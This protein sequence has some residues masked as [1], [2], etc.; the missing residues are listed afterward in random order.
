M[1]KITTLCLILLMGFVAYAQAPAN[2]VCAGAIP[3]TPSPE[4]GACTTVTLPFSTDGTTDSGVQNASCSASGLD[5]FFTWT[6]TTDGLFFQSLSPG[7]PGIAIYESCADAIAG[8][9]LDC[10]QT[11]AAGEL[12]GWDIGDDL[13]I[14]IYDF[15]GSTSDVAFCLQEFTFPLP[16]ANDD[17]VNAIAMTDGFTFSLDSGGATYDPA[18]DTCFRNN[19]DI[20]Y[21]FNDGGTPVEV[22]FDTCDSDF[23]TYINYYTGSCGA[24]VCEGDNDDS[25]PVC[26]GLQAS[27]RFETDGVSTYYF[28]VGGFGTTRTGLIAGSFTVMSLGDMVPPTVITQDFTAQLDETGNVTI[29]PSDIDN[30]SMDNAGGSGIDTIELDVDSFDCTN[31][32]DNNVVLTVTDVEGNSDTA[33]A[34]VTVVDELGPVISESPDIF[35]G[36]GTTADCTAIVSFE[37]PTAT[38]NC[39]DNSAITIEQTAGLP[40][41]SSFPV[42]V[43]PITIT[44]T[45]G[46]GNV[47]EYIFEVVI[48]DTAFPIIDCPGDFAV[49]ADEGAEVYTIPDWSALA[50]DNCSSDDALTFVQSPE[51]GETVANGSVTD[52]IITA[53]DEA[54]NTAE[55]SFA[56]TVDATLSATDFAFSNSISIYP[57]PVE[58]L[59]TIDNKSNIELETLTIFDVNGRII[60]TVRM[61]AKNSR[62]QINIASYASGI[63]F[64]KI[65]TS[66]KATVKRIVKK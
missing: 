5:Q 26:G 6:A 39:S 4:G 57:N 41:G 53:T 55:C 40:S 19:L 44:A 25:G 60:E 11:F 23:D 61:D 35:T 63:Y 24:L 22:S 48:T 30:G 7:N 47:T 3:I 31:L 33:T 64:A 46:L 1:R 12:G 10:T 58:N 42:G 28:K 9:E 13:I 32:G 54:G 56:L 14:Q 17:C 16:P 49:S 27:V 2:D 15:S 43:N 45:D 62:N 37:I 21:S 18:V 8:N 50:S 66:D 51:A 20:W 34:V 52:V 38:D 29:L 36:T 59:F 65:E